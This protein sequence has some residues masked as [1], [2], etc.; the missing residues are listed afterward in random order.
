MRNIGEMLAASTNL[1][2]RYTQ[3]LLQGVKSED[4]ARLA[5]PGG[6]VVQSNH[7]AFIFGHLALYPPRVMQHL[8]LPGG[9]AE[10]PSK[11]DSLFAHTCTCDDD[12]DGSIYPSMEE[13]TQQFFKGYEAAAK[14]VCEADDDSFTA[15]NPTV[16]PMRELF[17]T[18][19]A[20]L[21][22]YLGG[23]VQN[24]LGQFSAWRRAMG[25]PPA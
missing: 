5:R 11:Y 12:P 22:F 15:P 23:H 13:L 19:G 8:Q 14:A 17:P 4:F 16:G 25:M 18:V 2:L 20:M 3:R 10:C 24:H 6:V 7:P 21:N 9:E 1:S